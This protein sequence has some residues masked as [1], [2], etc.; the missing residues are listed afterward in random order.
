M[1]LFNSIFN[2]KILT[3]ILNTHGLL[4]YNNDILDVVRIGIGLYGC[5]NE[6]SLTPIA[7]LNSVI[8]QNRSIKKGERVGYGCSYIS[9]K[10]MNISIVPVG[11]ADGL[12]RCIN[13]RK[14]LSLGEYNVPIL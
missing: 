6:K 7:S 9:K 11:Y 8:T 13:S 2:K 5:T 12:K 3:H 1:I 14:E 4:N 10:D